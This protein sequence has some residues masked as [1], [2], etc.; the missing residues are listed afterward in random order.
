MLWKFTWDFQTTMLQSA[1][2]LMEFSSYFFLNDLKK[3]IFS[4]FYFLSISKMYTQTRK[5]ESFFVSETKSDY[6]I[7]VLS[8]SS[9]CG[10]FHHSSSYA[11]FLRSIWNRMLKMIIEDVPYAKTLVI[12]MRLCCDKIF[13]KERFC[14]NVK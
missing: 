3:W 1:Y 6:S 2:T 12:Q 13:G 5:K 10:F 7:E 4:S 11:H 9:C 14:A 8:K